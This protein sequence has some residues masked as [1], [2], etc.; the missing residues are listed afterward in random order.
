MFAPL[1]PVHVGDLSLRNASPAQILK[2]LSSMECI[3][4]V[5]END[6]DGGAASNEF[7]VRQR[8]SEGKGKIGCVWHVFHPADADKIR[9]YLNRSEFAKTPDFVISDSHCNA[10]H[11]MI[12]DLH[13]HSYS[14]VR[15]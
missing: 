7:D 3:S 4:D 2:S 1:S 14:E 12:H 10:T 15:Y 5:D 6:D 13:M 11:I 9:D 8:I